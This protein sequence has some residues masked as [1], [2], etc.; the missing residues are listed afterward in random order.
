MNSTIQ[1]ELNEQTRD[2]L[3]ND[4][5]KLM[6]V[7]DGGDG[8][9]KWRLIQWEYQQEVRPIYSAYQAGPVMHEM[10]RT[11]TKARMACFCGVSVDVKKDR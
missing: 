1:D 9:H 4:M 6:S 11:T 8:Y 7:C 10:G 2:A 3:T 5:V